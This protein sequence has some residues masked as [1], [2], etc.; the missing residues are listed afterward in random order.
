MK[1]YGTEVE[2]AVI[3]T[4]FNLAWMYLEKALG[5]H[6]EH[7]AQHATY[8]LLAIPLTFGL[9]YLALRNK[10]N[11]DFG[12]AMTWG[13]GFRSG[14]ILTLIVVLLSPL[15]QLIT[16]RLITP[17]FFPNMIEHSVATGKLTRPLAEKV[18]SLG[19]YI[20]QGMAGL[21]LFGAIFSAILAAVLR[22]QPRK[23]A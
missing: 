4:L 13:A 14:M 17:D 18:F 5:W 7:I 16:I 3:I 9:Y 15:V 2:W 19:A 6:D 21:L 22:T 10:R 1:K 20:L 8:T 12:G 11:E 23:E